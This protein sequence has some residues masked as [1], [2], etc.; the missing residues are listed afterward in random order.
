[1]DLSSIVASFTIRA[2]GQV[3]TG[4]TE[5]GVLAEVTS[6]VLR[7]VLFATPRRRGQSTGLPPRTDSTVSGS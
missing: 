7:T 5:V 2:T 3:V 1:M 6:W 4:P